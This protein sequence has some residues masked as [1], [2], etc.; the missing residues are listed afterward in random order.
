MAS[1]LGTNAVDGQTHQGAFSRPDHIGWPLSTLSGAGHIATSGTPRG[2]LTWLAG[3][4]W[5]RRQDRRTHP[6]AVRPA[7]RPN[8]TTGPRPRPDGG[9]VA[10]VRPPRTTRRPRP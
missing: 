6:S 5:Y 4:G 3:F 10:S 1:T 7:H 8:W 2:R 9:S